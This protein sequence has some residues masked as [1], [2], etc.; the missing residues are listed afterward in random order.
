MRNAVA[1]ALAAVLGMGTA[2][3]GGLHEA[4]S[5][6]DVPPPP[7]GCVNCWGGLYIGTSTG[8]GVGETH[9]KYYY[10]GGPTY[11]TDHWTVNGEAVGVFV[12]YNFSNGPLVYGIEGHFNYAN[13]DGHF[14]ESLTAYQYRLS[15]ELEWYGGV[16]L[17]AGYAPG[18]ILYYAFVGP[19]WGSVKSEEIFSTY[20][21]G[22]F[23]RGSNTD[24]HFG[25]EAGVG[26]EWAMNECWVARV[27][28]QHID[29][30]TETT[31]TD[32]ISSDHHHSRDHG[33]HQ[34][35][36]IDIDRIKIGI[37]YKL[38][39]REEEVIDVPMK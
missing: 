3:A 30:E 10:D 5:M 33:D 35:G 15:R 32:T 4:A 18:N 22:V 6:K 14:S 11:V 34:K 7:V 13:I 29:F 19:V 21:G 23:H 8:F 37:S 9:E 16:N 27:E 26:L 2:H 25:W 31:F 36:A 12:D 28:Y 20:T 24:T 39:G 38:R 1:A 17:R